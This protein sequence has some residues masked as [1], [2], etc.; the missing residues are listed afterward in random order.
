MLIIDSC[1][2]LFDH[3]QFTLIHGT[4]ILGPYAISLF[5][6]LDITFTTRYIHDKVWFLLWLS[7]FIPSGA[8]SPL[9][10]SSILDPYRLERFIFQCH[11][12]IASS[13]CLW[14]SQGKNA[15][16]ICHSI[17]Q[18]TTFCQNSPLCPIH[19]GCP[20]RTVIH[21]N[22]LVSFLWLRFSLC[23]PSDS[24]E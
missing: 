11:I 16:V 20:Y 22:I 4:N 6:T 17:L 15:E 21:V 13:F 14:G 9:S 2:F 18:W 7:L 3:F 10:S 8:V 19:L 5:K 12:F 23:L 24:W 1:Y